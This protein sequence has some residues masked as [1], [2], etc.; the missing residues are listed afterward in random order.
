MSDD[1]SRP[2]IQGF[3]VRYTASI[4][5]QTLNEHTRL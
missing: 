1:E 5:T 4:V 3:V 2:D